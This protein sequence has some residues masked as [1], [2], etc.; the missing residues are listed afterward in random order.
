MIGKQSVSSPA[1]STTGPVTRV[2]T[3]VTRN[4]VA[5]PTRHECGICEGAFSLYPTQPPNDRPVE[6][7]KLTCN[8]SYCK[9]CMGRYL[10][11]KINSYGKVF[12]IHCPGENCKV[13]LELIVAQGSLSQRDLKRYK[14]KQK[15][16]A[17]VNKLYCPN[18]RCSHLMSLDGPE[19]RALKRGAC[20][21]C[22]TAMCI[23]CKSLD[24]PSK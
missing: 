16:D 8:H 3:P 12:P 5:T 18:S 19:M 15:E 13:E 21:K 6:G 22:K 11:S 23:P 10:L 24:H 1:R 14:T 4:I 9:T 7:F 17:I 2:T 20:P